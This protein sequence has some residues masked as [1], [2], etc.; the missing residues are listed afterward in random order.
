[1]WKPVLPKRR[2]EENDGVF[3]ENTGGIYLNSQSTQ[4]TSISRDCSSLLFL[5]LSLKPYSEPVYF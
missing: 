2:E 5:L 3:D 1:M 4:S